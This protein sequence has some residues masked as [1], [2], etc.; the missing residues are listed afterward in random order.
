MTGAELDE[1]SGLGALARRWALAWEGTG[2]GFD[3][4]CTP[5]VRYEDPI[6]PDPLEGLDALDRHAGAIRQAVPDLRLEPSAAPLEGPGGFACLPWRAVGTHRGDVGDLPATGRFVA[7][8]GLHYV[9]LT[10]GLVRRARGFLDLHEVAIQLG[11]APRRGTL[12]EKAVLMLRG[13]GLRSVR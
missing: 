11:L 10:D 12:G 13:F 5:D 6:A 4:C 9:E 2:R 7:V 3:A 1:A 8:H